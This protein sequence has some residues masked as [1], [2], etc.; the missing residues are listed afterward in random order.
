MTSTLVHRASQAF[1]LVSLALFL[2]CGTDHGLTTPAAPPPGPANENPGGGKT[3]A[4][5]Q[6]RTNFS[7]VTLDQA[8]NVRKAVSS[9]L[10]LVIELPMGS[11]VGVPP[12]YAISQLDYRAEDGSKARSSTGFV[13]PVY[14]ISVPASANWPQSKIDAVN[15]VAGGLYIS[16]R[17]VGAI[18]GVGGNFA[19]LPTVAAEAPYLTNY[20]SN[21]KPKFNYTAAVVKRFGTRLNKGIPA[22]QMTAAE[23]EKSRRIYAELVK[24]GTRKSETPKSLLLIDNALA[25]KL[26]EE[27]EKSRTIPMNGAWS[28]AVNGTALRHGFENVPCAEFQSEVLRQAYQRAGYRVTDDFSAS[29]GN[30]LIWTRTAAVSLFSKSLY[31]A[32]WVPWDTLKFKPPVGAFLMN[33]AGNTPGHTYLAAGDDGQIIMDNGSPH[34]RDLRKTTQKIIE[35]MYQTGVFFLPPG[36]QP[37]PW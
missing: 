10:E 24:V 12:G 2:G 33:G 4:E 21:G 26:S 8:M 31:D 19:A 3:P 35:L 7:Q 28:V 14:V 9:V 6:K 15:Q 29:R 34:G 36:I 16:A 20:F 1:A 32:G 13:T 22:E 30:E 27:Y 11:V 23:Y 5:E 25:T 18:E 17:I 37:D